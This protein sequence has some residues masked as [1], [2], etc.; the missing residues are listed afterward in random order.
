MPSN[1]PSSPPMKESQLVKLCLDWLRMRGI[2]CY[3]NNT[4]GMKGNYRGKD[5]FV[6]FGIPGAPDIVAV[7]DGVYHGIECKTAKGKQSG[8]QV[9]FQNQLDFA[10]GV[11]L[12]VRS[13][14]DL[15]RGL[16]R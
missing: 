3:R 14:E 12:L 1:L 10:G 5:W 16:G 8:N 9:D 4:G 13:I 11:Y 2:F 7:I 6:R 15:Q